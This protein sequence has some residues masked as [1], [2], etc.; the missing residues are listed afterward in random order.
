MSTEKI[1][2]MNFDELKENIVKADKLLTEL[3]KIIVAINNYPL[4]LTSKQ[5]L[6][7]RL[8]TCQDQTLTLFEFS[9]SLIRPL[10]H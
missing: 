6:A 9:D 1:V 3:N 4:E 10:R 7:N 8:S 5:N 2:I